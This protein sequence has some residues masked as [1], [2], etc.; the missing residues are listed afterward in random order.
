MNIDLLPFSA[1]ALES[2]GAGA[3]AADGHTLTL[4]LA[5]TPVPEEFGPRMDGLLSIGGFECEDGAQSAAILA[6]PSLNL[7]LT[8]AA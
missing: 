5:L 3:V 4:P 7:T 6:V 1:F 2:C 8:F